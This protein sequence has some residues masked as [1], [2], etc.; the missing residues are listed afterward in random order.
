MHGMF[1]HTVLERETLDHFC[2]DYKEDMSQELP[3]VTRQSL[4]MRP[5]QQKTDQ[6]ELSWSSHS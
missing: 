5:A 3:K 2:L 1:D 6:N 4:R